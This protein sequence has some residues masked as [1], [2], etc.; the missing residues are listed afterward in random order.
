MTAISSTRQT[1]VQLLSNMSDGKEIRSYLQRFSE[2][3]QSRFA[4]IKIGGA[5]LRE[6]LEETV[7][8]LAFLS[9]D[10]TIRR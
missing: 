2:V 1:I 4:V 7:G 3:D 9:G 8:A 5:I 10:L 6:Q